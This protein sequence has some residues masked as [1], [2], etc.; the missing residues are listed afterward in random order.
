[1]ADE[2]GGYYHDARQMQVKKTLFMV[3]F[4]D[5][6]FVIVL[7]RVAA[8][9]SG[10]CHWFRSG[11][12]AGITSNSNAMMCDG[13]PRMKPY[14]IQSLVTPTLMRKKFEVA[15]TKIRTVALA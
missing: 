1:M 14:K 6:D 9:Q 12:S 7:P 2:R 3:K 11:A 13:R 8:G 5:H 10:G 15:H 4:F